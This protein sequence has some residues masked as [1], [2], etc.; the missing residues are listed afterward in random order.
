MPLA[1]YT[2]REGYAW[3]SGTEA[4]LA[5]LDRLRKGIGKMPEFDFGDRAT[6]GM[7]NVGDD[8]VLYRFMRAE[9][10]DSKGRDA[11]YLA[12]TY[13]SRQ[14]ARFVNADAVLGAFPFAE[15]L[16]HPP[17]HFEY[18]GGAA[19]P[20]DFEI[21]RN[22]SAGPFSS[23]GT[24]AAAGF[25]F[26]KPFSG[27]LHIVRREPPQ[28]GQGAEYRYQ[29]VRPPDSKASPTGSA[30]PRAGDE[31]GPPVR[32]YRATCWKWVAFIALAIALAEVALLVWILAK[33]PP[34]WFKLPFAVESPAGP[35]LQ[36][37]EIA[38]EQA[39]VPEDP[40]PTPEVAPIPPEPA[41]GSGLF[42]APGETPTGDPAP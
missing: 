27:T 40:E 28:E 7:I 38:P 3:Q 22:A 2:A 13:F 18:G 23:G 1:V 19:L 29:P 14:E 42:G 6:C 25:V 32:I 33:G 15:P 26:S 37:P 17:S 34:P 16:E 20:T 4:G 10:G 8:V 36:R 24:L 11:T 5:K 12:L 9:K 41:D 31:A 35:G 21:P 30:M 39:V